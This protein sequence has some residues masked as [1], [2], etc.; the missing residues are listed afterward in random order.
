MTVLGIIASSTLELFGITLLIWGYDHKEKV[1]AWEY[2]HL[3]NPLKKAIRNQL[4]K[5]KR[6]VAWAEKPAKHGKPD[7]EFIAGQVKVF[8]DVWQ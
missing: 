4:R 3:W 7:A 2:K 6:I 1:I 5:S 8:G